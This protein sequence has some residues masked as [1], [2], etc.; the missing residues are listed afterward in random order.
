MFIHNFFHSR[1]RCVSMCRTMI[2]NYSPVKREGAHVAF[3][4]S[5]L[6]TFH[7][8][9]TIKNVNNVRNI[10]CVVGLNVLYWQISSFVSTL[11]PTKQLLQANITL[12]MPVRLSVRPHEERDTHRTCFQEFRYFNFCT[13]SVD[14]LRIKKTATSLAYL[15]TCC[16]PL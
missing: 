2:S 10:M 12:A 8:N 1:L 15:R 16:C 13:K 7:A 11:V 14:T 9:Y 6:K 3:L 4:L 5:R